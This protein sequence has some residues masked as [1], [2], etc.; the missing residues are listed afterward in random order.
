MMPNQLRSE[1]M[2]MRFASTISVVSL[3]AC[4]SPAQQAGQQA[5][6][7]TAQIE[8]ADQN[9]CRIQGFQEGTNAFDQC[10]RVTIEQQRRPHRCTYCRSLD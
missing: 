10:L 3:V 7:R 6:A 9:K 8:F 5:A 4:V 2:L 1:K